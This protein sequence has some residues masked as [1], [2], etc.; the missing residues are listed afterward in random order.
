LTRWWH[1]RPTV[2]SRRTDFL[3]RNDFKV[4][5]KWRCM[6]LLVA[7]SESAAAE[8][9]RLGIEPVIIRSAIEPAVVDPARVA[10]FMNEWQLRGK[11]IIGTSAALTTEKDALTMVKAIHELSAGRDDFVFVHC[12]GT[13]DQEAQARALVTRLGL[14]KVY[15]FVGFQKDIESLYSAMDV[16][17][18]SST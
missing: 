3:V 9:R 14:E 12:G 11:R 13:G 7:I 15:L 1:R 10:R 4:R 17:A 5:R 8:P 16:F 6:D 18:M 2:F